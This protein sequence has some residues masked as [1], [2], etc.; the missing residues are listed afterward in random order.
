MAKKTMACYMY[1]VI[2]CNVSSDIKSGYVD[3][4]DLKLIPFEQ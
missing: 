1:E 3:D 2:V 4:W